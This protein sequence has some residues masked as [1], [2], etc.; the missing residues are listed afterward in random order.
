MAKHKIDGKGTVSKGIRTSCYGNKKPV[1]KGV[2]GNFNTAIREAF[3]ATDF[4]DS[5]R[6]SRLGAI[7]IRA[8]Q[9]VPKLTPEQTKGWSSKLSFRTFKKLQSEGV[10]A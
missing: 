10:L 3:L 7:V 8:A 9:N 4:P 5:V 6:F 2:S 1:A